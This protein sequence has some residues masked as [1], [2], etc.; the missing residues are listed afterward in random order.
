[1]G[2]VETNTNDGLQGKNYILVPQHVISY[3]FRISDSMNFLIS[4]LSLL[5]TGV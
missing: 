3:Y 1:M 2:P 4:A 5:L